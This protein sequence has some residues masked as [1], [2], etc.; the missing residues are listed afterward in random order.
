MSENPSLSEFY[1]NLAC[2]DSTLF[3]EF[4]WILENRFELSDTKLISGEQ[5]LQG[6]HIKTLQEWIGCKSKNFPLQYF[7][8]SA[9]FLELDFYVEP[10]VLIPRME[11]EDIVK[12][13]FQEYSN[14]SINSVLDIGAGSGC[15]GI[16]LA[17]L[18]KPRELV[19]VE[20]YKDAIK[21]LSENINRHCEEKPW[22]TSLL[23]VTFEQ[24]APD[25]RFDLI[26][27]NPP[28]IK[29]GDPEVTESVYSFEPHEALYGGPDGWEK[30]ESWVH[31]A[32][33]FLEPG[34]ILVF[35][36]SYDQKQELEAC[37][38]AFMPEFHKDR[39]GKDRFFR[40]EKTYG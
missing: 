31:K 23:E 6:E 18:F 32:Y 29:E 8:N 11:T 5:T 27:S 22:E 39:F 34:G 9:L 2:T 19:L 13:I 30:I 15:F 16:G 21:S 40:I 35:E 1:R 33:D 24:F 26:V 14:R 12:W 28:Y 7:L 38:A 25:N 3:R 37:L 17:Q 20:P 10:G 4:L 36:M